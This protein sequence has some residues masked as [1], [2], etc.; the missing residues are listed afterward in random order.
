MWQL[1]KIMPRIERKHFETI[2]HALVTIRLDYCTQV[3]WS[4]CSVLKPKT[5]FRIRGDWAFSEVGSQLWEDL[6][7]LFR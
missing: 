6:V 4:D 1:A 2:I 7:P 5:S 3:R